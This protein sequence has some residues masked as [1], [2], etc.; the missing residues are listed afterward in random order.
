MILVLRDQEDPAYEL[1]ENE[2][3]EG[4]RKL[5][6]YL[7]W[8]RT[9]GMIHHWMAPDVEHDNFLKRGKLAQRERLVLTWKVNGRSS[10][11]F[12]KVCP[13]SNETDSRKFI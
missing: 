9:E 12:Y 6:L 1:V 5:C 3:V 11:A 7:L 2:E 10:Q 13:E 8:L 4:C